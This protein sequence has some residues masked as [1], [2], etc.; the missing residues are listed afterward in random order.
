MTNSLLYCNITQILLLYK[1]WG[2]YMY[3]KCDS[4]KSLGVYYWYVKVPRCGCVE[5]GLK[6]NCF[7]LKIYRKLGGQFCTPTGLRQDTR[8]TC[9]CKNCLLP[10]LCWGLH[11]RPNLIKTFYPQ[12]HNHVRNSVFDTTSIIIIY[13]IFQWVWNNWYPLH[14]R[15]KHP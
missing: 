10:H 8:C 12:T 5:H 7:R 9:I 2:Y 6:R 15:L 13:Q 3:N 14:N 11:C 1:V 4:R